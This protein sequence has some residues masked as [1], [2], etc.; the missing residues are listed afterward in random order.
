FNILEERDVQ[1]RGYPLRFNLDLV[2]LFTANPEEYSRSGKIISQ[3]KD[4]IGAEI[5]T[6]YPMRRELG[7]AIMD[8]EAKVP[9]DGV[10]VEVPDFMKQ[11]VEQ[12]TIEARNS[13]YVNQ[14]SGVSARLSIANFE[15]MVANARRRSLILGEPRAV[16]RI[17]DLNYLF[18]SSFG[19]IEL[20]PFREETVTEFQVVTRIF[21]RAVKIVFDERVDAETQE[22]MARDVKGEK[23]VEVSDLMPAAEYKKIYPRVPTL[24]DPVQQM[25]ATTPEVEASCVEFLLEGLFASGRLSRAKVGDL[26]TYRSR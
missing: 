10:P 9:T 3:L 4:R 6:H 23:T 11:I 25:G 18:T 20:D 1:I 7:I 16:P 8:Q 22:G 15:T 12:I 2:L 19:K 17:S 13:P 21:E 24:W 26:V 14:K 5:R